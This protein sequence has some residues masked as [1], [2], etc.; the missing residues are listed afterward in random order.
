MDA[1]FRTV[2]EAA[3]NGM[4]IVDAGGKIVL[5]NTQ[6]E[7]MFG[8]ARDELLGQ[9]IEVL[10][11]ARARVA[12]VGH[13]SLYLESPSTR[14]MGAGRELFGRRKDGSEFPIEIG[15]TVIDTA[16]GRLVL[17]AVVDVTERKRLEALERQQH[18]A[19]RSAAESQARSHL[20][21]TM[22]HEIRTPL[23]G[24]IGCVDLLDATARGHLVDSRVQ[25]SVQ[26]SAVGARVAG[27]TVSSPSPPLPLST[28][29]P[30][31]PVSPPLPLST[32]LP[33]QPLSATPLHADAPSQAELFA[34]IRRCADTLLNIVNDILDFSKLEA[35][36]VVVAC[37]P[38]AP[39][40]LLDDVAAI[41][42]SQVRANGNR[43]TMT[44]NAD[45]PAEVVGDAARLRQVLLNLVSNAVK[46][47]EQ[48]TVTATMA[49]ESGAATA[50]E[51]RS[52]P[53]LG[54]NDDDDAAATAEQ[55]ADRL[56]VHVRDTGIGIAAD[57]LTQLFRPFA[58]ADAST[59]RKFGGTGLGL[60]ISRRLVHLMGGTLSVEST[61]GAGSCFTFDVLV[62]QLVHVDSGIGM[63]DG[64]GGDGGG[65]GGG[66]EG[67]WV[68][69]R[70]AVQHA[71]AA[72][73]T[74]GYVPRTDSDGD[75]TVRPRHICALLADDDMI[76]RTV[77]LAMLR[78]LGC[79][80][81]AV[82]NGL[83]A[84]H[85]LAGEPGTAVGVG[86]GVD[87]A[88]A[89]AKK[90][91]D[92]LLLDVE[93]PVMD[94]FTATAELRRRGVTVPIVAMTANAL[95]GDRERCLRAGMDDYISK[96]IRL[97]DL[98]SCIMR[99]TSSNL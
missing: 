18:A 72:R 79:D 88:H 97:T 71:H 64:G 11:P 49:F 41:L 53:V 13:R 70:E 39:R 85:L 37:A 3:P 46:F 59:T 82:V 10:V 92:I 60:V 87:A 45:V 91:Y 31:Q 73:P 90:A 40:V 44:A 25:G 83:E 6:V 27:P 58:Q 5:L 66:T 65:D 43:L 76:N 93:M 54:D 80:A 17:S 56:R 52:R 89:P 2:V 77:V 62:N 86:D 67:G 69:A 38:F 51:P 99:W 42:R 50:P 20:L 30:G 1:L 84:V 94:G 95:V 35:G 74:A 16:D 28:P 57:V 12:H 24:I 14:P 98:R 29:L 15:L 68:G 34:T 19:A 9:P 4:L 48:G 61:L 26:G 32:P 33:G 22:S 78:R 81:D 96:P 23:T 7:R 63:S 47:T 75:A 55:G 8:F 36:G 21:A